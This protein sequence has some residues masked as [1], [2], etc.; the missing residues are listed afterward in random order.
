M[1]DGQ[2]VAMSQCVGIVGVGLMGQAARRDTL[3]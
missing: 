2:D 3:R 1:T